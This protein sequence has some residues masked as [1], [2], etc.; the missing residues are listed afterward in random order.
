MICLDV[1]HK[2]WIQVREA[3]KFR[4]VE[5]HHEELVRWREV[6]FLAGELT[7]KVGDILA[8]FLKLVSNF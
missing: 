3:V 7:V 5:I 2:L 1:L 8:M 6:R 4:L